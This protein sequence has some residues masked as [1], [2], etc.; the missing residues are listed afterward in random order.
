MTAIQDSRYLQGIL[1]R[2]YV[3]DREIKRCLG[4]QDQL[5]RQGRRNVSLMDILEEQ[6]FISRS[7][8]ERIRHDLEEGGNFNLH[9]PGFRIT[10]KVGEGGMGMV[11]RTR[12]SSLARDVA[13]KV[14][15]ENLSRDSAFVERFRREAIATAQINHPHVVG[16]VDVGTEAEGREYIVMEFIDGHDLS[17]EMHKRKGPL[18]ELEVARIG[19]EVA[20]GLAHIHRMGYI[21][22]DVKPQN[23]MITAD[24]I[25]KLTDMGLARRIGDAVMIAKEKGKALGTPDYISPEQ[26]RGESELDGR[27]DQY[28][29]G[30]TLFHIL[31]G[32]VPFVAEN[33]VKVMAKHMEVPAEPASKL[34]PELKT[35]LSEVIQVLMAKSRRERY[36]SDEELVQDLEAIV[37]GQVPVFAFTKLGKPVPDAQVDDAEWKDDEEDEP[38]PP[39][40]PPPPPPAPVA[41]WVMPAAIALSVLGA[42]LLV[43]NLLKGGGAA[44][45]GQ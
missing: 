33:P 27:A 31:T 17:V 5:Y 32:R 35:G 24:R 41:S 8:S 37:T 1:R 12:Q 36:P 45:A 15:R 22:R 11:Y 42:A 7:Q 10:A 39:E 21:H 14:L 25:A 20:R 4:L 3:T 18:D 13:L 38:E 44:A 29:L 26:I 40:P 34:R 16:V 30:G 6:V 19:L 23:I 9:V 2:D 43:L 28:C